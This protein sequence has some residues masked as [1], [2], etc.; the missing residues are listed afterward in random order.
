MIRA[1][2]TANQVGPYSPAVVANGPFVFVSGRGSI[3]DGRYHAG[4]IADETQAA[5]Q[6]IARTA[7]AS[8]FT[9]RPAPG[10]RGQSER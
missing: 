4:T 6:N 9:S 1:I 8:R 10:R 3:T 7:G 5:L 2:D